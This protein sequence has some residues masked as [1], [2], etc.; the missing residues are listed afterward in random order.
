MVIDHIC[1]AVKNLGEGI[2][3]W[4]TTFGYL[5]MTEIVTN[6][7]QQVKVVFLSKKGSIII[8]LIEPCQG[9]KTLERFVERG[10]G[11]HH[12]CFKCDH[13]ESEM[14]NLRGKGVVRLVNPQPGEAFDNE[15]IAFMLTRFGINLEL[16]DTDKKAGL[17]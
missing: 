4:T 1:F 6:T 11:F 7:L 17:L 16:I 12:L 8:K 13:I 3:N 14:E 10:G 9:N 2:E 5:Q 15:N